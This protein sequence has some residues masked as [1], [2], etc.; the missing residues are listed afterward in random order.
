MFDRKRRHRCISHD[1]GGPTVCEAPVGSR[2]DKN[3][4][5]SG[6]NSRTTS[7]SQD[8]RVDG[9]TSD[10]KRMMSNLV[11]TR[12]SRPDGPAGPPGLQEVQRQW[13]ARL[14]QL[15]DRI[16]EGEYRHWSAA[17]VGE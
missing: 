3:R 1:E 14:Q 13:I 17:V 6:L 10:E 5:R 16:T 9:S 4:H 15:G 8:L 11:A 2:S 7:R 12:P